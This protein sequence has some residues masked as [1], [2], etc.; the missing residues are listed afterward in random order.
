[1]KIMFV[2]II[3]ILCEYRVCWMLFSHRGWCDSTPD[4]VH[5]VDGRRGMFVPGVDIPA[6]V[7]HRRGQCRRQWR[8]FRHVQVATGDG[9]AH[10]GV[11][12]DR[13][14]HR[15]VRQRLRDIQRVPR[16]DHG[17]GGRRQ[18]HWFHHAGFVPILTSPL[19]PNSTASLLFVGH[20]TVSLA[21]SR[22]A[23]AAATAGPVHNYYYWPV[24]SF[25]SVYVLFSKYYYRVIDTSCF[26][27][28]F[29]FFFT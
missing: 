2:T 4:V 11:R 12:C 24:R 16:G 23:P 8:A 29:W 22:L 21:V 1:M 9:R 25:V 19:T 10:V 14:L 6:A 17:H 5:I 3:I 26:E 13:L 18:H 28:L 15:H 20:R 7:P 27:P